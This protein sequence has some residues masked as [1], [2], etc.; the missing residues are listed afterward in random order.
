MGHMRTILW[1]AALALAVGVPLVAA[2]NSPLLHWRDPVYIV[3]G[4]AGVVAL[5]MLLIQPLLAAGALPGLS[6]SNGRRAHRVIGPLLVVAVVAHVAG[7]WI[8]SP[9]DVIDALL[10]ASPTSFSVWGVIA[11]W[12]LFATAI[13]AM[14]RWRLGMRPRMWRRAHLAFAVVIV[15]GSVIHAMLIDGTMETLSKA[16]LCALVLVATIMTILPVRLWQSFGQSR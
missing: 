11:M 14:F 13:L 7:L 12:A 3:A 15:L 6:A 1:W 10:F 2:A 8:T 4:F 16:A 5:I 9:P